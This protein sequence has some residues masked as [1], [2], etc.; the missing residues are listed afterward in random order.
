MTS[1]LEKQGWDVVYLNDRP[2]SNALVKIMIRKFR[3]LMSSYLDYFYS[4][5]LENLGMFDHVLIVKGEGIA[6]N[7]VNKIKNNHAKGK[8]F[9]YLWDGIKNST[10]ALQIASVVDRVFTFDPQD[11]QEFKFELLPLFYV[12]SINKSMPMKVDSYRWHM[13][14]IGSIHGDR[15][16]VISQ[17]KKSLSQKDSFFIFVYFPSKLLFY[18]RKF[19]DS[20]FSKFESDELS[21]NSLPKDKAQDIFNNSNA[22]LDI[23]HQNQTGLTM[24]TLEV[25]SLGKKLI[26]TNET[27]KNYS[28]YDERAICVI[29]RK[30]PQI[31]ETFFQAEVPNDYES[32]LKP[33]ELTH[34]VRTLT[35][36]YPFC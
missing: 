8:V 10:G 2:S 31:N 22:V 12:D 30:N 16:K 17:V 18:F 20:S 26:T 24:R 35:T 3:F 4:K 13:S 21:L 9:L 34:W 15:L 25:L 36:L 32:L 14:F 28:F 19:F 23:H 33:Y 1:E 27:I 5:K 7:I 11:A 29:D 6:P